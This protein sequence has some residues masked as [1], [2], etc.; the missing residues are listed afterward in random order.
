MP[1][2]L[3]VIFV[4]A[5][6]LVVMTP[7]GLVHFSGSML[8][9]MF[10]QDP[11]LLAPTKAEISLLAQN[12]HFVVGDVPLV[13]PFIALPDLSHIDVVWSGSGLIRERTDERVAFAAQA[14]HAVNAKKWDKVTLRV[15]R[16]GFL[17]ESFGYW[18]PICAGLAGRVPIGLRCGKVSASF[19]PADGNRPC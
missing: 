19:G 15:A 5:A 6:A 14:S 3:E 2:L 1:R 16:F 12:V 9:D 7:L 11:Y 8:A 17:F 13:L 18:T 10:E 4:P